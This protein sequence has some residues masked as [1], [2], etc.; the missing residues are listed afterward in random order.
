MAKKARIEAT[1]LNSL[2]P[3]SK[4]E[5]CKLLPDVSL[6]TV[7]LV[8]GALCREGLITKVGAARSTRYIRNK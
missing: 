1:V 3:I 2:M 7:E 8:L 6:T 4:E 5:I